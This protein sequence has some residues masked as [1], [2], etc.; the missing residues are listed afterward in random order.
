MKRTKR[1]TVYKGKFI[2]I[3]DK[4]FETEDGK[5]GIWETVERN[6]PQKKAVVIFALTKDKEVI[7][8]KIYRIP[9]IEIK[10]DL[11]HQKES[12][13]YHPPT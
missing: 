9:L 6:M 3:V 2:K 7:L 1:E 5:K 12:G 13:K 11:D 10:Q 8:E 4:H